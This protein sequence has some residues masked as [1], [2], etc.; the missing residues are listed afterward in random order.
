MVLF[1]FKLL[2]FFFLSTFLSLIALL[3]GGQREEKETIE[4]E[5]AIEVVY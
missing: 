5:D 1:F 3:E 4:Q 2:V